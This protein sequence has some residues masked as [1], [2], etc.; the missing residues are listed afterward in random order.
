[1]I[2]PAEAIIIV[3]VRIE[4]DMLGLLSKVEQLDSAQVLV[5]CKISLFGGEAGCSMLN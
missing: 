4:E 2:A 3:D 5:L 1:M